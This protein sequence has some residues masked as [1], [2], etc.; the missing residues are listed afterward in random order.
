MIW[1]FSH[2]TDEWFCT[3]CTYQYAT[4]VTKFTFSC[5]DSGLNNI[6]FFPT[7]YSALIAVVAALTCLLILGYAKGKIVKVSPL[8]SAWEVFIIGGIATAIGIV[9]GNLFSV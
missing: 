4:F 7:S 5:Y 3:R 2:Y 1:T 9:A 8:K 6:V